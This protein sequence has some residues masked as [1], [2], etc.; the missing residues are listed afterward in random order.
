MTAA[1]QTTGHAL[2]AVPSDAFSCLRAKLVSREA[3]VGVVGL[4]YVGLPFAVQSSQTGFPTLGFDL[5]ASKVCEVNQG[6]S[7]IGD[8]SDSALGAA[9]E[10]GFEATDDF[11][12]LSECDV[13][14]VAVPTPLTKNLVPDLDPILSA[15]RAIARSLR[16]GQLIS[17]ESTTFPG[18]TEEVMLP[19]LR[20]AG[21]EVEQDFFLAHSPER[22][23]PGNHQFQTANTTKVV[24][25]VG[26][27]SSEL[28]SL[29]YA[30]AIEK[31][32][33][34]SSARVAEMVKVYENIFRSVNVAL[35]NEMALLC[36][37]MDLNVWEVLDAAFTKP[38]GI[39]PFYPGPGVGG[40]CI[41]LDP[42]YLE[43]KARE[44]DFNTRFVALAGEI[45]RG[46]PR[47]VVQKASRV[48][49]D[50]GLAL[51]QAKI[52]VVGVAYKKDVDDA[53][54]SPSVEVLKHLAHAKANVLYHDP[55]VPHF[56][57]DGAELLSADLSEETLQSCDLVVVATAHTNVDYDH[58]VRHSRKVLDTRNATHHV[59]E[60][61]E[62]IVLL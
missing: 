30:A 43:F 58:I 3:R 34:V 7:Y 31:T 39:M 25:G 53:R 50:E 36:D 18:T 29:F 1:R 49:S 45:N 46:M 33:T 5:N 14:V 23:D 62:K 55:Y 42:H 6:R 48:L 27:R 24:G 10:S 19:I 37:R 32:V 35:V 4:G 60:G 40:H 11:E 21:L 54:E 2:A 17:L 9:L 59:K 52:L 20:E 15:T 16:P 22:V 51:S 13:V 57:L 56:E 28:A 61:R 41:P 47:F 26:P 12:R 8:V 44:F 38:F